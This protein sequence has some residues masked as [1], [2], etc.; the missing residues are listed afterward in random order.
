MNQETKPT[1]L[2]RLPVPAMGICYHHYYAAKS[3]QRDQ[4]KQIRDLGFEVINTEESPVEPATPPG[5]L[6]AVMAWNHIEIGKNKY[7]WSFHDHLVEDCEAVGLKLITDVFL[8]YH[9]PDWVAEQYG[10]TDVV[11][12]TG[13]RWGRYQRPLCG[14]FYEMRAFSLAHEGA[15]AAAADFMGRL[16]ARYKG[17]ATVVGHNLFQELGLNYPHSNTWYG[18]DVSAPVIAC[19]TRFLASRYG[20]LAALDED[21]HRNYASFDQAAADP[22][23]FKWDRLPHR[24]WQLWIEHRHEYTA[25][26]MRGLHD[27]VKAAD[28]E[29]LTTISAADV[30]PTYSIAQGFCLEHLGFVDLVAE[31][32]FGG[33]QDGFRWMYTHL[34]VGGT[35]VALSNV[36][37]YEQDPPA[38]EFGRKILASI[39]MGSRWNSIYG[40]HWVTHL[41]E[42]RGVRV[43]HDNVRQFVDW[44]GFLR[45]HRA[46]FGA[47]RSPAAEVAVLKPGRSDMI[48]FWRTHD[49]RT[50]NRS[51]TMCTEH[52]GVTIKMCGDILS[53]HN[54]HFDLLSRAQFIERLGAY[55]LAVIGEPYLDAALAQA[56]KGFVQD[57][58]KLLLL[59]NAA[60]FDEHGNTVDWFGTSFAQQMVSLKSM[61]D[62]AGWE[63]DVGFPFGAG[64][65]LLDRLDARQMDDI[66][67]WTGVAPAL[68]F[69]D[70]PPPATNYVLGACREAETVKPFRWNEQVT[71]YPLVDPAGRRVFVLVQRGKPTA[72]VNDLTIAWNAGPVSVWHPPAMR[73]ITVK[74]GAGRL[75]LPSWKDVLILTSEIDAGG[76]R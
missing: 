1:K 6:P 29:A 72:P 28:P 10:D 56:V 63:Q 55:K 54:V 17:S 2:G 38:G 13:R 26:F 36:N 22:S 44:I 15:A 53:G 8:P 42:A 3:N 39:G 66:C 19:F 45:E 49:P 31:K 7:D 57:G 58:G 47:A 73:A 65:V 25:R 20:T 27:A 41:D 12:P 32:S 5:P 14:A 9:L 70:P 21:W 16:A 64:I 23:I 74:P 69:I 68:T 51:H 4:L 62:Y 71:A 43:V 11:A 24:G 30:Y 37:S 75:V 59:P 52:T 35:Q 67:Q 18:Q 60:R 48:E 33:T 40:W 61:R 46:L 34:K 76:T 50:S